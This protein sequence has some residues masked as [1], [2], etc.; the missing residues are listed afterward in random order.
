MKTNYLITGVTGFIGSSLCEALL[1]QENTG[2][3]YVIARSYGRKSA[4]ERVETILSPFFN[5][6][7]WKEK[8]IILDG[9]ISK[10]LLGLTIEE[11]N[12]LVENVHI[13]YHSAASISFGLSYDEAKRINL[14]STKQMIELAKQISKEQ[15]QCFNHI[16]TAFVAGSHRI[17]FSEED[18]QKGQQFTNTYE[19]TKYETECYLEELME[20]LPITIFRPSLVGSDSNTG[21]LHKNSFIWKMLFLFQKGKIKHLICDESSCMNIIPIDYFI[22]GII[23]IGKEPKN[24]GK[25]YHFVNDNSVNLRQFF[26]GLCQG[27]NVETPYFYNYSQVQTEDTSPFRHFEQYFQNRYCFNNEKTKEILKQHDIFCPSISLEYLRKNAEYFK[28]IQLQKLK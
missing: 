6:N 22:D 20:E 15:F 14:D 26:T 24:I 3:I 7:D 8:I 23:A 16:S 19:Q 2:N 21:Y 1:R 13:I 25:R 28:Q 5:N 11:Y 17:G 18:L 9:D 4:T 12:R 27:L 10:E